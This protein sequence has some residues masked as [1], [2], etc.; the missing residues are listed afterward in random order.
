VKTLKKIS[1]I[2]DHALKPAVQKHN[3]VLTPSGEI[4]PSIQKRALHKTNIEV[5]KTRL[6]YLEDADSLNSKEKEE[7][8]NLQAYIEQSMR[9]S[10]R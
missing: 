10:F 9:S 5:I 7:M 6:T 4:P 2:L 8:K 3:P 1:E